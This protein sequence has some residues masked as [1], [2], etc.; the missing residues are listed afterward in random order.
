M[1]EEFAE[2]TDDD[3]LAGRPGHDLQTLLRTVGV[4][5]PATDVDVVRREGPHVQHI[6]GAPEVD[7][8]VGTGVIAKSLEDVVA[9]WQLRQAP[10]PVVVAPVV[11]QIVTGPAP[12]LQS[13]RS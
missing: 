10:G 9:G 1:L 5:V 12:R 13:V 8:D 2:V 6:P 7:H 4:E 3:D 11:I